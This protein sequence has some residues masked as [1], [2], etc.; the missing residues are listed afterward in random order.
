MDTENIAKASGI[1]HRYFVYVGNRK[2]RKKRLRESWSKEE[3]NILRSR[4]KV[5]VPFGN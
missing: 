3:K 2:F 1:F 5:R 4:Y